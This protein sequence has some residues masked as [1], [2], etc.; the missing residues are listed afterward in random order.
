MSSSAARETT[1]MELCISMLPICFCAI[2][3]WGQFPKGVD[4]LLLSAPFYFF[5]LSMGS[6]LHTAPSASPLS[7]RQAP[8]CCVWHAALPPNPR[9]PDPGSQAVPATGTAGCRPSPMPAMT[10]AL[11]LPGPCAFLA[12]GLRLFGRSRIPSALAWRPAGVALLTT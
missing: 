3:L 7:G 4:W 1:R 12:S 2:R 5:H 8:V 6:G 10:P 9:P 11:A